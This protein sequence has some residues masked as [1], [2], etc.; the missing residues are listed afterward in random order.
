ML[1]DIT[2]FRMA[3][4][5]YFVGTYKA[6]SHLIDTGDGLILMDAGYA[7]TA[8]VIV[9]SMQMLGFDIKDVKYIVLSHGHGD[10]VNGVP[11]LLELCTAKT[12]LGAADICYPLGFTP[13][14]LLKDGDVIRCG[15]TE[16]T[17]VSTPGHTDG[18]FSFF[19]DLTE[20]GR[21]YRAGTF[22]GASANQLRKSYLD[23]RGLSYFQRGDF[24]RSIE[25]LRKEHVDVFF[26]N[27]S[28]QN[29]T[30]GNYEKSLTA[31]ENPFI[32]PTMWPTFLDNC[33]KHL[34]TVIAE[35]RK[36]MFVNYAHRG[37]SEYCPE[38]TLLSFYTCLYM[39]AN[40][41]ETDV[42]KTKDGVL[43]LFH[44]DDLSRVTGE[45]GAISDYTYEELLQF[46]VAKNG[47]TDKI[48]TF[49]GFLCHFAYRD[50]T[51]AIELKDAFI[52][53]EV[54]ELI[55][56]YGV[57]KKCVITSFDFENI[58]RMRACAP[59]LKT[60]FLTHECGDDLLVRLKEIGC[61]QYC[62]RASLLTPQLVEKWQKEGFNVRAWGVGNEEV[63]RHAVDC[64]VNGMTVNFPDKLQMYLAEK[65]GE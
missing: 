12:F 27:H 63:M 57:Q 56:R 52:E 47:L 36:T 30:R 53:Q 61:D 65:Y 58:K 10:H 11:R 25:R 46:N 35:E 20:N 14:V 8:D 7:E 54:A 39:R 15:N 18:T 29:D 45:I 17:C 26:A 41:I 28:W 62:P 49:E 64:G 38:N 44:D 19:F 32:D 23:K 48:M 24:Y 33:Q 60:G 5:L 42:R 31:A 2:P 1:S 43:V 59:E 9:D 22:G 16:I 51:L 13:D 40:G 55:K 34:D 4:N 21:T 50:L 6:S 3:G 37:A